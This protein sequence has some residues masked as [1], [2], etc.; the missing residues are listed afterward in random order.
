MMLAM[1]SK[2]WG[3]ARE[4]WVWRGGEGEGEGGAVDLPIG[5]GASLVAHE[6]HIPSLKR[7]EAEMRRGIE[8]ISRDLAV[9]G[10]GEVRGGAGRSGEIG[11]DHACSTEGSFES[12]APSR[13]GSPVPT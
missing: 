5:V 10:A 1:P 13:G 2:T 3:G 6:L 4:G 8:A 11:R 12:P 9:A 7:K